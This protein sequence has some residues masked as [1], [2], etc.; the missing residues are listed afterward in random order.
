MERPRFIESQL[1]KIT[2]MVKCRDNQFDNLYKEMLKIRRNI[3]NCMKMLEEIK[4][5]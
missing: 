3:E 5:K 2:E 1:E 4:E